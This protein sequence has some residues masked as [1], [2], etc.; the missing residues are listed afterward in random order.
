MDQL[1]ESIL[2]PNDEL[3]RDIPPILPDARNSS[4]PDAV[5]LLREESAAPVF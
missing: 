2:M 4:M 1:R 3:T 5:V